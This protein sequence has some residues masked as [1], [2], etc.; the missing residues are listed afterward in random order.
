[1]NI[2]LTKKE[3]EYLSSQLFWDLQR[4]EVDY[5]FI[6]L[7]SVN[8]KET[9]KNLRFYR[10]LDKKLNPP[11]KKSH[12]KL[13]RI[14][15]KALD[16]LLTFIIGLIIATAYHML[17]MNKNVRSTAERVCEVYGRD[18]QECKDGIDELLDISDNE[19][20]NNIEIKGE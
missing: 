10:R 16:V 5:D 17:I 2:N 7:K 19:V 20:Q 3:R 4:A 6:G 13:K 11:K 15:K 9:K 14:G 18:E 1:M 8:T 12:E